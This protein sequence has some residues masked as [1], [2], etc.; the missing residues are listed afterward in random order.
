MHLSVCVDVK[1]DGLAEIVQPEQRCRG[2]I[3]SFYRLENAAF[4]EEAVGNAI[5]ICIET[6]DLIA[7]VDRSRRCGPYAVR[8]VDVSGKSFRCV[9]ILLLY[10]YTA[11]ETRI[12]WSADKFV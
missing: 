9:I 8:I 4:F 10:S 5:S 12:F 2:C 6:D 11:A 7:V 1:A 3:C